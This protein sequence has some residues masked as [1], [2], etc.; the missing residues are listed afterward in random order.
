MEVIYR[1]FDGQL[2]HNPEDCMRH[3]RENPLF[4]M[5]D[6]DG[7]TTDPDCAR[8]VQIISELQGADKFIQ[9]CEENGV[10]YSG[11]DRYSETGW[12]L[13][14]DERYFYFP[15]DTIEAIKRALR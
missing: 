15:D 8:V 13:W 5:W 4:K 6:S 7:P 14:D 9:L 12:Y 1:A 11:I 2:F 10:D 3:E